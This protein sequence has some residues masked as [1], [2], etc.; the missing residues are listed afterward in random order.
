MV[1]KKLNKQGY[2]NGTLGVSPPN[3]VRKSKKSEQ[4]DNG[5]PI[6]NAN[7]KHGRPGFA[8]RAKQM[9][10]HR[11]V[12][13]VI[14]AYRDKNPDSTYADVYIVLHERFPNLFSKPLEKMYAGNISKIIHSDTLWSKAYFCN[15]EELIANAK[16]RILDLL[17]NDKTE[18]SVV[19]SAYDK[20]EK[21]DIARKQMQ[22][23]NSDNTNDN[24]IPT[25]VF[26]VG[27]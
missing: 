18:G 6:D 15:S 8:I 20:L 27:E 13:V 10:I 17:N 4:V 16:L 9:G 25:F 23:E 24:N 22:S 19:L 26:K 1:N 5:V 14:Q 11:N 7:L 3:S 21:W 12:A 2:R